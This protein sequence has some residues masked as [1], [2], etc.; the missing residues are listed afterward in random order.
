LFG[1]ASDA[2]AA[3]RWSRFG[4]L[5][6]LVPISD[7]STSTD[8]LGYFGL[9]LRLNLTG[10]KAGDRLLR[11]VDTAFKATIQMR[12]DLLQQLT[13][14]FEALGDS[15]AISACA[16]AVVKAKGGDRP[17]ECGGRVTLGFSETSYRAFREVLARAREQADAKYFGLDLRFD[18][19][20]PTLAGDSTRDVTA[21]QAGLAF[22]RRSVGSDPRATAFG[23]QGR[24]GARYSQL[25]SQS[26]SV[27]WSLD[28]A[29]GFEASRL[30][31]ETQAVRFTAALEGRYA[32]ESK[33]VAEQ[34]QTD[35]LV[36]RGGLQIPV[37][38]GTSITV[39]GTAPLTGEVSPTLSVNFN[40]ALLMGQ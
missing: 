30:V 16:D 11:Q 33:A 39:A 1:G 14:A 31:S 10:L 7:A 9:R 23:L 27:T 38:G 32:G 3:A 40:W 26:D 34:H 37:M 35:N 22:G 17:A 12:A 13:E 4:D 18:T 2:A 25:R 15:D 6:V 24:V 19:G 29:V 21:L 8:K 20:D 28:V 36:L 5:S